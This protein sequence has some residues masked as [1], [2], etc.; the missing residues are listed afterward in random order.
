MGLL[1]RPRVSTSTASVSAA[2]WPSS[3]RTRSVSSVVPLPADGESADMFMPASIAAA[4]ATTH[5]GGPARLS[6]AFRLSRRYR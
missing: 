4:R 1:S 3:R 2:I 5:R 6:R